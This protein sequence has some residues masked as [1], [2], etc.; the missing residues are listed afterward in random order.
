MDKG[1]DLWERCKAT[2]LE[3]GFSGHPPSVNKLYA[4]VRGHRVKTKAA[5]EFSNLICFRSSSASLLFYNT[6]NLTKLKGKPLKLELAFY[7]PSWRAKNGSGLYVRPDLSNFIK[8]LEDSIMG[9]FGLDDSAV[10][11]LIAKKVEKEGEECTFVR[12][13][14]L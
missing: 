10:V 3:F 5:R 14:F 9:A 4:T 8:I 1:E 12:L 13:S 11:E 7:R 6:T 2:P